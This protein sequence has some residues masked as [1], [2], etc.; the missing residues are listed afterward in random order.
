MTAKADDAGTLALSV[1]AREAP[2]ARRLSAAACAAYTR[3]V[4]T[5]VGH[6]ELPLGYQDLVRRREKLETR[7]AQLRQAAADEPASADEAAPAEREFD[8]CRGRTTRSRIGQRACDARRPTR[9]G[10][11]VLVAAEVPHRSVDP[12]AV[13]QALV[14]DTIYRE[15]REEFHAVAL[16]YRTELAIGM[17][18]L[19]D[20]I[21]TMNK[22]LRELAGSLAEQRALDPPAEIGALLEECATAV[23]QAQGRF[24]PLGG[25]WQAWL[26]TVQNIDVSAD[27]VALV[28]QQ[29]QASETA[30][31]LA[32]EDAALVDQIGSK[33][34]TLGG[35]GGGTREVVVAAVLRGDQ[36]G[37]KTAMEAFSAAAGKTATAENF[38]LDAQDRKLRGLRM[39][40]N[41]RRDTI[42]QQLQLEADRAAPSSTPR[43]SRKPGSKS[44][45]WNA[46]ARSC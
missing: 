11:A 21:K 5:N 33:I 23:S 32:E 22:A 25:Q 34:E 17:L 13:D 39:R 20:P 31:R 10:L 15:D 2:D 29:N 24:T 42:T 30:R 46:G 27:V 6:T 40:L 18:L 8:Q 26:D 37:L 41:S 12:A 16:Q 28:G 19:V 14:E 44:A 38:E 9:A 45:T 35:R 4:Q 3:W 7:L 36:A 43:R 1:T